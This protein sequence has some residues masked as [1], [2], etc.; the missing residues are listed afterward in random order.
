MPFALGV[1]GT[2]SIRGWIR[3][4]PGPKSVDKGKQAE[5]KRI[6][7]AVK[8]W[9]YSWM[10]LDCESE[11]EYAISKSLLYCYLRSPAVVSILTLE[12]ANKIAKF[13]WENV[14]PYE[15]NYCFYLRICGI[16]TRTQTALTRV[17]IMG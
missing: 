13:T 2:L 14:E 15:M 1:G 12:G 5:F 9:V 6:I 16:M 17:L 8:A 11:E 3:H 4:C 7:K 10:K